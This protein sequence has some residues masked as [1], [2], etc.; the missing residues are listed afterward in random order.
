MHFHLSWI[1]IHTS[2]SVKQNR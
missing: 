1:S 2:L